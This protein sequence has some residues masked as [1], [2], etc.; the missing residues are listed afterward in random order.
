MGG[1]VGCRR[2]VLGRELLTCTA[3]SECPQLGLSDPRR[4][5]GLTRLHLGDLIRRPR[6]L[7]RFKARHRQPNVGV[8]RVG[9]AA[10]SYSAQRPKPQKSGRVMVRGVGDS[11]AI[12]GVRKGQAC[13]IPVMVVARRVV[14]R[15]T[16]ACLAGARGSWS[17]Q[18]RRG[19]DPTVAHHSGMVTDD[20][21]PCDGRPRTEARTKG[22]LRICLERW[23]FMRE[24]CEVQ[25]RPPRVE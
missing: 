7:R 9:A 11:W 5:P 17:S 13:D 16:T 4:V 3:F 8:S 25:G 6:H 15:V 23:G 21:L 19:L 10:A 24:I 14:P 22:A 12:A 18:T 1:R 2:L 20:G